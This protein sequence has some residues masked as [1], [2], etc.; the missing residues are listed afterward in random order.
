MRNLE[1]LWDEA[2]AE[3]DEY[4]RECAD[5]WKAARDAADVG[6]CALRAIWPYRSY[7]D[8][9]WKS[10]LHLLEEAYAVL[11]RMAEEVAGADYAMARVGIPL[12][13]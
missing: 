1:Q 9:G 11:D 4:E 5:A 7:S 3:M 2:Y 6:I 8:E 12:D 10:A 13:R